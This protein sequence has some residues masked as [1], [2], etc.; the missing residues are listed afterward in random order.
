MVELSLSPLKSLAIACLVYVIVRL[1]YYSIA[2]STPNLLF[3][4]V[5]LVT[6]FPTL[7]GAT[8]LYFLAAP[9]VDGHRAILQIFISVGVAILTAYREFAAVQNLNLSQKIGTTWIY[10]D[11]NTTSADFAL[12]ILTATSTGVA[13][14]SSVYFKN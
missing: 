10:Q 13:F 3:S 7:A 11:G 6:V 8:A 12:L 2:F 9:K 4:L 14:Y 5:D 1:I